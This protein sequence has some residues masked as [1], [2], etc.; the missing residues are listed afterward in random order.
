MTES[1]KQKIDK[2]AEELAQKNPKRWESF[3]KVVRTYQGHFSPEEEAK[4]AKEV[5]RN[6]FKPD[7]K[8]IP[9]SLQWN[10]RPS[11]HDYPCHRCELIGEGGIMRYLGNFAAGKE[12]IAKEL[13]DSHGEPYVADVEFMNYLDGW[14]C[15][16]C[17]HEETDGY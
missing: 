14:R 15:D 2:Y 4:K 10:G 3:I 17:G 12:K 13:H 7:K 9:E 16:V 6:W 1:R 8:L 11:Q 5:V